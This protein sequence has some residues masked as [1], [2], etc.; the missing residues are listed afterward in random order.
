[1][2]FFKSPTTR[3]C[4]RIALPTFLIFGATIATVVVALNRMAGEV[5]SVERLLTARST[6]A[7]ADSVLRE[8]GKAHRDYA[9]WDDAVRH[10]YGPLDAQFLVETFDSATETELF[11]DTAYIL[12]EDGR[13]LF[14]T[15]TGE[16]TELVAA[17]AFS[18]AIT[19]LLA[20]LPTDGSTY[21]VRTGWIAGTWGLAA[22][23]VG[24]IVP[25]TPGFE[26]Q[27]P[28][29][30]YLIV[31]KVFG[32]TAADAV[33]RDYVIK[34]MRFA[35]SNERPED[36]LDLV[37]PAGSTIATLTW[38]PSE[39]GSKAHSDISPAV[40]V[41][42]TVVGLTIFALVLIAIRGIREIKK[43]EDQARYAAAHDSLSGLPNRAELIRRLADSI[44]T[45][46]RDGTQGAL[47]FLD[48]DGFKHVNDSY[49]HDIGDRLLRNLSAGFHAVCR[50]RLIARIGGDEFAII[51]TEDE[52]VKAAIELSRRVINFIAQPV[53]IDGRAIV[54]GTS[55]GIAVL[56]G[57]V[58]SAEEALRR[59]DVAMYEA[60]QQGRNRI[61]TY[62]ASVD[63]ARHERLAIAANLRDA[64]RANGLELAY[65]AIF[66]AATRRIVGAEALLRWSDADGTP[67]PPGVFI[68]IAEENGLIDELGEWTL[69]RACSDA[70]AWK[71]VRISV[72]VS[73]AQFRNPN[74][75]SLL[76]TILDETGVEH[77]CVEL[78]VTETY[79]VANPEQARHSISA[80]R[81]MGV[82]VAL[83]DFGTGYSSIGYLRSFT[84]DKLKLDRSLITGI[85][86]DQRAQ[87][88]VQATIALA[89]ALGLDVVAEGVE[90]EEEAV[91]LRLAGCREFQG[92][93]LARPCTAAEFSALIR[94]S[95]HAPMSTMAIARA[96]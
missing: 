83:D 8:I 88:F 45:A 72:N 96:N 92:F 84:F 2:Q 19:K 94:S 63:A 64:L 12:D 29:S 33:A 69:R 24:P 86:A 62:D 38:P 30:R 27:R 68:P 5:D 35:G 73:P 65:Q 28:R 20:G 4:L 36:K 18:P 79:L 76:S 42:L 21:Q 43:N 14:G 16:R 66:D 23:A 48:L 81:D 77:H 59:A 57:S 34:G 41:M 80:V 40:I 49:G 70:A 47:I 1:M 87:R 52:P 85:I 56:D 55:I 71:G 17:D 7:A 31:S 91:L 90:N 75:T 25:T 6:V 51:L 11:F 9:E 44:A 13:T 26:H 78:E 54:I 95:V 61:F 22:V 15:H 50:D 67:V 74:F 32:Q 58:S 93:H 3:L 10:L 82:S 60:K 39:L 53:E 46:R 37:D 89:D